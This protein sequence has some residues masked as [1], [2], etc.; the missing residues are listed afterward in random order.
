MTDREIAI[1]NHLVYSIELAK[2][3]TDSCVRHHIL[4]KDEGNLIFEAL[5][6]GFEGRPTNEIVQALLDIGG[7]YNDND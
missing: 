5:V 7:N 1:Q 4:T 6:D 3:I 2:R